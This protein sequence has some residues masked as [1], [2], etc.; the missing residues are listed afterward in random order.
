VT[1]AGV[2]GAFSGNLSNMYWTGSAMQLWVDAVNLGYI[3]VTSD[4]RIKKDV[5]DAQ[6]ALEQVLR[7]RPITYTGKAW[8]D[9]FVDNDTV[10][11]S[12]IAHELQEV[13]PDCVVG[14]KDGEHPQS[15]DLVPIVVRLT[16]AV[17]ELTARIAAL[18][19]KT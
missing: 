1:K 7:W 13:S 12:F 14:E 18:E 9:L 15:L 17:Q 11:H 8:G 5:T 2:S 4:Y 19:N 6:P 10:R 3:S 16:K